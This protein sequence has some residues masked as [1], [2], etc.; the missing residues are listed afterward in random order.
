MISL[1]V[2]PLVEATELETTLHR[3]GS[4]IHNVPATTAMAALV[5]SLGEVIIKTY[6]L[7]SWQNAR[8]LSVGLLEQFLK[9]HVPKGSRRK[10]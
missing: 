9:G 6:P 2:R 10:I 4:A 3:I 1:D 8:T 7:G 5:A